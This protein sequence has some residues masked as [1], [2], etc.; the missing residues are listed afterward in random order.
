M[1]N[2][3]GMLVARMLGGKNWMKEKKETRD[4]EY[5]IFFEG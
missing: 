1:V 5:S 3:A 4:V 2:V